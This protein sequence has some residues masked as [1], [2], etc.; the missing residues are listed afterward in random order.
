MSLI[1]PDNV[2]QIQEALRAKA[3]REP[4]CRFKS[5][6]QDMPQGRAVARLEMFQQLKL[7]VCFDQGRRGP[8]QIIV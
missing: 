5:L 2:W 4:T 1:T 3:K 6:R 7:R 8:G